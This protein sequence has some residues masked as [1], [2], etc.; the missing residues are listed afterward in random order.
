M[1]KAI[2]QKS[3]KSSAEIKINENTMAKELISVNKDCYF[4]HR[5]GERPRRTSTLVN[6]LR[7]ELQC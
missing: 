2:M 4:A 3:N 7:L 5:I 1:Q 6:Q